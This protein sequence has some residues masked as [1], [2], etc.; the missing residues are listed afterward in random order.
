MPFVTKLG[1][2]YGHHVSLHGDCARSYV[3]LHG[4]RVSLRGHRVS[5]MCISVIQY[6]SHIRQV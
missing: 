2:A 4:Q 3:S 5:F 6:S 1:F